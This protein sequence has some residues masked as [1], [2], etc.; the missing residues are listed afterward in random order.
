MIGYL[1]NHNDL[2]FIPHTNPHV[3][4]T[5]SPQAP[6][7]P[8]EEED[9]A[10]SVTLCGYEQSL[11][12]KATSALSPFSP[13]RAKVAAARPFET[14]RFDAY[15][16]SSELSVAEKVV[17][18]ISSPM[19]YII[20]VLL[21]LMIVMIFVDIMAISGTQIHTSTLQQSVCTYTSASCPTY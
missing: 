16:D 9:P 7:S 2:L 14:D 11:S 17:Q 18:I 10:L 3:N 4:S 5:H 6:H 20:L 19:P 12:S 1:F 15:D 13:K 8:T 21:A